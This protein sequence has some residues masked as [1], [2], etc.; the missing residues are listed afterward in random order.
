M[1]SNDK[2]VTW[3]TVFTTPGEGVRSLA[4]DKTNGC[5]YAGTFGK[6]V[7][8][9]CDNGN[10]WES[11]GLD[12]LIISSMAIDSSGTIFAATGNR[13]YQNWGLYLLRNGESQWQEVL[14]GDKFGFSNV[15]VHPTDNTVYFN[16]YDAPG[17]TY[18]FTSPDGVNWVER[19][20][21][22]TYGPMIFDENGNLI[23]GTWGVYRL[24]GSSWIPIGSF[25][26][27]G[28]SVTSLAY[29]SK[30]DLYAGGWPF[31]SMGG[32]VKLSRESNSWIQINE[33]LSATVV[34]ALAANSKGDVFAGTGYTSGIFRTP[35]RGNQWIKI[36]N[37]Q[38][39]SIVI[40]PDDTVYATDGGP[41]FM[42]TDDGNTWEIVKTFESWPI[43][44]ITLVQISDFADRDPSMNK[45]LADPV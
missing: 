21:L 35:D 33:G 44:S 39:R 32:V 24:E 5:V 26:P 3:E 13:Y 17:G 42:S 14:S 27:E 12:G 22:S 9:S 29:N 18:F 16:V 31:G 25:F 43:Y 38:T 36:H 19:P 20:E 11:M 7:Y 4:V 8:R 15:A 40:T 2:G 10:N 34:S 23:L 28:F 1:R 41:I 6:G 45:R 37:I 30:G